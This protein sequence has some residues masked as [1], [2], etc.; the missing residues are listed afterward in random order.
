MRR[1]PRRASY[2]VVELFFRNLKG[3][4][5]DAARSAGLKI[6]G[7]RRVWRAVGRRQTVEVGGEARVHAGYTG[8]ELFLL[9]GDGIG[10][11]RRRSASVVS[12]STVRIA[13][14]GRRQVAADALGTVIQTDRRAPWAS[15]HAARCD[16]G[17]ARRHAAAGIARAMDDHVL[18]FVAPLGIRFAAARVVR[19]GH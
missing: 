10:A 9:L 12:G 5:T 6:G 3:T 4:L 19:I 1:P 14:S 2:S 15:E 17:H 8:S 11:T 16:V 7:A 13:P 18:G